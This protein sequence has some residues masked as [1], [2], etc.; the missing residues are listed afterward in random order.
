MQ[1]TAISTNLNT[2]D[3]TDNSN[4]EKT[5]TKTNYAAHKVFLFQ[6]YSSSQRIVT[7]KYLGLIVCVVLV[8][9]CT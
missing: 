2:N 6:L 5:E 9:L 7:Y 1:H 4:R 8:S 3:A